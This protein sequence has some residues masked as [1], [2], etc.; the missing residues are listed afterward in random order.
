MRRLSDLSFGGFVVLALFFLYAPV[1]VLVLFSFNDSRLMTLP[2]SGF[3]WDWY[4]AVFV[5]EAMMR[6]LRNSL[7]VASVATAISLVIGTMAA[8][9]LDRIRFP[10]K[11]M[12]RRII[13]LPISLPGII[14]G[15]SILNM[16]S[17]VGLHLSLTTVI[18]GHTAMLLAI[19]VT[20]V[21]AR[22]QRM[23]RNIE[24]AA[25]DL[26][27]SP[28]QTFTRVTL[29]NIR[30][31]LIGSGLL[32]FTVS[33]DDVPIT[34]FLTGRENTLP[35]YIYS[36]MRRGPSPEFN[37]VSTMIFIG[38]LALIVFSIILLTYD[39]GESNV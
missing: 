1:A 3:T 9:A 29:P 33:F 37:A 32:S 4:K 12:F 7:Y 20:Q 19:V 24:E 23:D 8:F 15:I 27:A 25:A 36:A 28:W 22:L 38:S 5:N 13:L 17:A 35:M 18:L 11:T 39:K 34:F 26:G 10:G 31:A 30:S 14:I 6:A 16:S 2:L 21:F